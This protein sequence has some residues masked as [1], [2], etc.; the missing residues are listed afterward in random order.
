MRYFAFFATAMIA[1]V[2]LSAG[3]SA[4]G[5]RQRPALNIDPS[6]PPMAQ[7]RPTASGRGMNLSI[8]ELAPI[9]NFTVN[10]TGPRTSIH[11][12]PNGDLWVLTVVPRDGARRFLAKGISSMSSSIRFDSDEGIDNNISKYLGEQ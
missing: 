7:M 11:L 12:R 5:P 6:A 3:V 9:V 4:S 1:A 2:L 8:G 10:A